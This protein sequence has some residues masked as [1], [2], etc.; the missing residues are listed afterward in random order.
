MMKTL[1]LQPPSFDGF[2]GGAGSR[3]Q[4]RREIRSFW[5]PTWL[6]QPAALVPG[7]KLIDA[8]PAGITLER[9][10]AAGQG[11]R[12]GRHPHLDA[13]LRLGRQGRGGAEGAEPRSH[14]R[15]RRR[16]GRGR[17]GGEPEGGA[18]DRF[19]RAQRVRLHHQGDRRGPPL[20][21]VDGISY[22]DVSGVGHAQPRSRHPR[23]HGPASLRDR[24]L[25]ARPQDRGLLH[26]LSQAPVHLD[27]YR[28]R[29]QVALHL[30]PVAAD[31]RRPPLPHA[32]LRAC[33]RGDRARQEELPAGEGVL[34]RRRHLHRRSA[35]RRGD[36]PRA[37]Q[38]R[39]HLVVQRQGERAA[40]DAEGPQGERPAPAARRLR[41]RATSRSCTTSRRACGSRSPS[42]SPRIATSSASPSTAPSSSA[43]PARPRRRS[44]R[45]SASPPRSTRTRSRSRSRRPIPAPS[46][47]SRRWRTAGSTS[48]MPS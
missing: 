14:D 34:L 35:A 17:A 12:A 29:L 44:R 10:P 1:F 37:R 26:R 41:S 21:K 4:A 42:N 8:P 9:D 25:Q 48:S 43:C 30:L 31:G 24:G 27:L 40:R 13:V 47:T 2:D 3:Y 16:Q 20:D 23:G 36:R 5:Y 39:R 22:R 18:G 45:R 15:L 6:A 46:S 7:S 33:R 11:L 38:A 32:Q 28:T 19:R